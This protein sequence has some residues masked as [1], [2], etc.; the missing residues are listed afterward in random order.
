MVRRLWDAGLAHRDIK[1]ANLMVLDGELLLIDVAFAQVRPSPWRQAIDLANMMLVLAVRSDSQRVY[2]QALRLFTPEEIAE[3]FAATRGVASPTQ[4]RAMMKQDGRNLIDEFRALAPPR[5]RISLQR[6]SVKRVA[7]AAVILV[8]AFLAVQAVFGLFVPAQV[9]SGGSPSCGTSNSMILMAQ[10]VPT[11]TSL[12][13]V[14]ALPAGWQQGGLN[15]KRGRSTFWLGFDPNGSRAVEVTL[16]PPGGCATDQAVEVPSDVA[17][18]RRF[19]RPETLPPRLHTIRTY[20]F[21]GGCVIY[22]Y[23]LGSKADPALVFTA[24]S[25]LGFQPRS[26]LVATVAART[27]G[28]RLCGAGA[29]PCMDGG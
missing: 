4:L 25:A 24:D 14:G 11:A 13:C 12:P 17:G 29:P 2:D 16:L 27:H 26:S 9:E 10:S 28:L 20:V 19:E 23:S 8:G 18:M 15:T 6:W 21:E 1:P 3:A 7:L 22:D 5:R